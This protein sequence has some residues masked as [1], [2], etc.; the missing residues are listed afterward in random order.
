MD[1]LYFSILII[2]D[3]TYFYLLDCL[4]LFYILR[5]LMFSAQGYL[6]TK[7]E[8]ADG[9]TAGSIERSFFCIYHVME[10]WLSYTPLRSAYIMFA[11]WSTQHRHPCIKEIYDNI[12]NNYTANNK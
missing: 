12:S 3:P 8:P 4:S 7:T 9:P 6:Q 11:M 10:P 5:K 2:Y 1:F